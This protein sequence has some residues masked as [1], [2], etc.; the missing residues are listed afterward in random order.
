M[1]REYL[2]MDGFIADPLQRGKRRQLLCVYLLSF[3]VENL[4]SFSLLTV[5]A[6]ENKY[7]H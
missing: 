7:F 1:R 5:S 6:D 4:W 2:Q 3:K